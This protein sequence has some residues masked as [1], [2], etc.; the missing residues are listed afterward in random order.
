MAAVPK[1]DVACGTRRVCKARTRWCGAVGDCTRLPCQ[2]QGQRQQ[3]APC[4]TSGQR[5]HYCHRPACSLCGSGVTGRCGS[6]AQLLFHHVTQPPVLTATRAVASAYCLNWMA[7]S[8]RDPSRLL[9]TGMSLLT[10]AALGGWHWGRASAQQP[11]RSTLAER[12]PRVLPG[13]CEEAGGLCWL[14]G[15]TFPAPGSCHWCQDTGGREAAPRAAPSR[16]RPE[17]ALA[18]GCV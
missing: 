17:G 1:A 11:G 8:Q 6:R 9:G 13:A 2:Q 3:W 15:Y 10:E 4:V 12:P 14:L 5:P 18:A 16:V 7:N